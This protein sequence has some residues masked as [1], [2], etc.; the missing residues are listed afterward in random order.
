MT[1]LLAFVAV[2]VI[3]ATERLLDGLGGIA[4][5]AR[6]APFVASAILS[7]MEAENVAV[8]LAAAQR[9]R[10]TWILGRPIPAWG[11]FRQERT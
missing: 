8:G 1:A 3:V 4:A 9:R 7:G 5:A 11:A 10:P 2:I 6:V